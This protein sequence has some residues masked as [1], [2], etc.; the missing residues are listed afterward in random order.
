[1]NDV[2]CLSVDAESETG[3]KLAK[4]YGVRGYPTLLFLS[5]DGSPR[6]AIGGYM[7]TD[8]FQAEVKRIKSGEGTIAALR[9][10]LGAG[11][12]VLATRFD[13]IEKLGS[14]ND[15]DAIAQQKEAITKAIANGQGFEA[16]SIAS[17]WKLTQRLQGA[18][19]KDLADEQID[20][21]RKLDPEG[22]SE[23][24]RRVAFDEL[25]SSVKGTEDLAQIEEFLATETHSEILFEGWNIVYSMHDRDAKQTTQREEAMAARARARNAA[26]ELWKHTPEK[27]RG[28]LG[29]AIAW[30]FYEASDELSKE[31]MG[32]ALRVAEAAVKASEDDVNVIDTY[33]C[34]LF[35]NGKVK[36]ALRQVDRCIELDPENK[37]WR[38]RREEFSAA[39]G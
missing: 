16:G 33:A 39:K 13:L 19:M 17:R 30:G 38:T 14:F 6:D 18:G 22:K 3:S 32:F 24:M 21:I 36:E 31:E 5:E 1:M 9:K 10:K 20:A 34:C 27:Y 29:N 26:V 25:R 2:I 11:G 8:P 35:I 7:P 23:A 37:E 4:K 15:K 28:R 12:D